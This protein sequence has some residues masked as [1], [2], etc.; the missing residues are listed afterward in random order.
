MEQSAEIGALAKALSDFQA[1]AQEPSKDGRN[2]HLR[3][4]FVTL[5]SAW[6]VVRP[7][8]QSTGLSV[9]QMTGGGG[10]EVS[11]TT[12]L[13]HA[14]GQWMRST[15]SMPVERTKGLTDAQA[16]G[17]IVT[18]LRRYALLAALGLSA[19]DDDAASDGPARQT[20]HAERRSDTSATAVMDARKRLEA[21]ETAQSLVEW[22]HAAKA[23]LP[24]DVRATMRHELAERCEAVGT[25][26]AAVMEAAQ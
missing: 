12:Q 11:V 2:P 22:V 4:R 10:A 18:Y 9:V 26:M 14:S 5:T 20:G 7:L 8:L 3:N 16:L 1:K 15:V 21:C 23:S 17:S 19:E 6:S 13:Q 25:T 24:S